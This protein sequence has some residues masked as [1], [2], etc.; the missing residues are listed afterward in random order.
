MADKKETY[1]LFGN[2]VGQSLSPLMHTV[3]LREMGKNA[4]YLAFQATSPVEVIGKI[5]GSNIK[6]ASITVPFKTTIMEY[7]NQFSEDARAIGAVNTIRNDNG[8]LQGFNTDWSGFLA[9]LQETI[10]IPGKVCAILGAGGAA[11]AAVYAVKAGGGVALI[12][13]R[14]AEKAAALARSLGCQSMP[15]GDIGMSSANILINATPVGMWPN[16]GDTPVEKKFLGRFRLVVDLVYNPLKTRLLQE[17]QESGCFTRSGL[18]MFVNQAAGQIRI[19]TG[20]EGPRCLMRKIVK[21]ELERRAR[22][23]VGSP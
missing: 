19:W 17:A 13:N 10:E 18:G 6:G 11:R 16:I 3:A 1:A 9:D 4:Q 14:N 8:K 23:Q 5:L 15:L 2:P 20:E 21:E 12:M 7:L 22:L